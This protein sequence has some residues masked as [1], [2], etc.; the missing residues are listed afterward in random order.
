MENLNHN[1]HAMN[2]RLHMPRLTRRQFLVLI[3]AGVAA[4]A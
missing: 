1:L 2:W 4:L 3:L